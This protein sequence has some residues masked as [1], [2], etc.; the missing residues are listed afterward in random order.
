MTIRPVFSLE[1]MKAIEA[2]ESGK[3]HNQKLVDNGNVIGQATT[4]GANRLAAMT[5]ESDNSAAS[6]PL[7]Y[8]EQLAGLKKRLVTLEL[9]AGKQSSDIQDIH[10]AE[11]DH[12]SRLRHSEITQDNIGPVGLNR[13]DHLR[14]GKKIGGNSIKQVSFDLPAVCQKAVKPGEG[15][16]P[17][18]ASI[19]KADH[20]LW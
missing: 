13:Q 2:L 5:V 14:A 18:V 6:K 12:E 10:E 15:V 4:V 1:I 19:L 16:E 8:K 11:E 20:R 3:T 7:D 9:V 17:G